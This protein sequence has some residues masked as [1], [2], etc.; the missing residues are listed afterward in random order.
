MDRAIP[1]GSKLIARKWQDRLLEQHKDRI[2][3]IKSHVDTSEPAVSQLDHLRYNLKKEQLLEDR[4][5]TIDR[6]NRMLLKKMSEIMKQPG[7]GPPLS[8]RSH[9]GPVSLNRDARKRELLR[10]A[11]ENQTILRRIHQAQPVYNHV[12][13]EGKYRQNMQYLRNC[14]EFPVII[15]KRSNLTSA[16]VP[17]RQEDD[18]PFS[19]RSAPTYRAPGEAEGADTRQFV[20]KEGRSISGK[21]FLIEMSTNGRTL[22]IV[23]DNGAEPALALVLKESD[24]QELLKQHNKDYGKIANLLRIQGGR[25]EL[26]TG[27]E[28]LDAET[29]VQSTA[30]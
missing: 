15:R 12:E 25:L 6:E 8:D 3:N 23:A 10:I 28:D 22:N 24:H 1:C 21:Y 2:R 17:L 18:V 19:A 9:R 20:L 30:R 16:L 11:R 4:Y 29:M 27:D 26:A 14:S 13:W 5:T 7:S